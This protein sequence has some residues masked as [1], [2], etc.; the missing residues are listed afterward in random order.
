[1][2]VSAFVGVGVL[3]PVLFILFFIWLATMPFRP[4]VPVSWRPAF[5]G[6]IVMILIISSTAPGL[7]TR[8]CN[9]WVPA[10]LAAVGMSG[11]AVPA[12]FQEQ[13]QDREYFV[14]T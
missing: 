11:L 9:A 1:V 8:V 4:A 6:T 12:P 2:F 3:G 10:V 13:A 5:L 14:H 7:G